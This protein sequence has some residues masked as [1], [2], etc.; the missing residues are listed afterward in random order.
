MTL[1]SLA[2]AMSVVT[3][4]IHHRG[5]HGG[6]VP[7]IVKKFVFGVLAKVLCIKVE[8]SEFDATTS[9]SIVLVIFLMYFLC[10]LCNYFCKY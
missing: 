6:E 2:T 7:T 9:V 1:V 5:I 8:Y 3:L 10:F 4:N